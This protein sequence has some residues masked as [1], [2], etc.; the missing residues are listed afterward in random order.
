M[1]VRL[2]QAQSLLQGDSLAILNAH[3]NDVFSATTLADQ[4]TYAAVN[5]ANITLAGK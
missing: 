5:H 4:H 3:V 1:L 2:P